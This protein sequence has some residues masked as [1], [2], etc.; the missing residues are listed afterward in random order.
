MERSLWIPLKP[1]PWPR[2]FH[3]R[4][5]LF[6]DRLALEKHVSMQRSNSDYFLIVVDI[7][8]HIVH[9]LLKNSASSDVQR[10]RYP[11]L[12]NPT[13]ANG[14]ILTP[15][16]CICYTNHVSEALTILLT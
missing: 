16:L 2:H 9:V 6:K 14:N 13:S 7:G 12:S 11:A 4:S 15:I 5:P 1:T 3:M 10:E 8:I